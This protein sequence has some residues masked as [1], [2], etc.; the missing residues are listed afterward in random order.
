MGAY[1]MIFRNPNIPLI[2]QDVAKAKEYLAK[3][4]YNGETITITASLGVISS[5]AL[6]Q[7]LLKIGIKTEIIQT[8][9]AGLPALV[10]WDNN[11]TQILMCSY[12]TGMNESTLRNLLYP[13]MLYN[14]THYE[15]A[16]V[17]ELFD[18]VLLERD[19]EKRREMHYEIQQIV[20]DDPPFFNINYS[21][22]VLYA[23]KGLGGFT[24][25]PDAF[26]DFR[27]VYLEI[28]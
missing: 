2:E 1:E 23:T 12:Q 24:I 5:E 11:Q 7:Q 21:E 3:S 27:Q 10:A 18:Q 26:Y 13:R 8:D 20:A 25:P 19:R 15:N 22:R 28:D 14:R 17:T 4:P 9:T 6:Q 16:R